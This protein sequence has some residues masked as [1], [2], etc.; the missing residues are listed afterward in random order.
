MALK[1]IGPKT[2]APKFWSNVSIFQTGSQLSKAEL[3]CSGSDNWSEALIAGSSTGCLSIIRQV[4]RTPVCDMSPGGST[5]CGR[6]VWRDQSNV[7]VSGAGWWD[8]WQA[9]GERGSAPRRGGQ[10]RGAAE[11]EGEHSRGEEVALAGLTNNL[12][13]LLN[14]IPNQPSS[15]LTLQQ[16]PLIN[17]ARPVSTFTSEPDK[18]GKRYWTRVSAEEPPRGIFLLKLTFHSIFL[19]QGKT[20]MHNRVGEGC[21]LHLYQNHWTLIHTNQHKHIQVSL[22]DQEQIP[23]LV[24]APQIGHKAVFAVW[25]LLKLL[26]QNCF[27][28]S[29]YC[30]TK[31][32][33]DSPKFW[34]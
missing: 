3:R 17:L 28:Q 11:Q 5:S 1:N 7:M 9:E 6:A 13:N 8:A 27:R 24:L 23:N 15:Q 26:S 2:L 19:E 21:E 14:R 20:F 32:A 18:K 25:I 29:K 33:F 30:Y 31:T 12:T 34:L 4:M 10:H 22:F 16:N